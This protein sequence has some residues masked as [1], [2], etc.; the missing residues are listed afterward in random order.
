MANIV[1]NIYVF[2][3]YKHEIDVLHRLLSE[4]HLELREMHCQQWLFSG[5]FIKEEM[6]D[7]FRVNDTTLVVNT[8]SRGTED[9]DGWKDLL[10]RNQLN[11]QMS[12]QTFDPNWRIF[13]RVDPSDLM[14]SFED[15]FVWFGDPELDQD[16]WHV[17]KN[18]KY[19]A[20]EKY[21]C[22]P[23]KKAITHA[24][25]KRGGWVMFCQHLDA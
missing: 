19:Q 12:W 22:A 1:T 24:I 6:T 10:K 14:R 23:T 13:Y 20:A 8:E 15:T 3:G 2:K 7:V 9:S 16:P 17:W 21:R 25:E 4:N 18:W 5:F 11:I